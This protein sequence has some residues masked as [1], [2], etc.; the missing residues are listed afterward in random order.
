MPTRTRRCSIL[1]LAAIGA[2]AIA[3]GQDEPHSGYRLRPE[4]GHGQQLHVEAAAEPTPARISA[5]LSDDEPTVDEPAAGNESQDTGSR[6]PEAV[7]TVLEAE[8]ETAPSH[9]LAHSPS[10]H[11]RP[12]RPTPTRLAEHSTYPSSPN[13][14]K[15]PLKLAPRS[16]SGGRQLARPSSAAG[17]GSLGTVGGALAVVLGLFVVVV[18][19]TRRVAPAGNAPLPKEAVELLGRT[20]VSGQHAIQLVRI[21]SRLLLVAL[22]PQGATTLTEI[23][24][25]HEVE[26]LTAICTRQRPGSSS[27]SFAQ[28]VA[29]LE[30]ES[31]GRSFV[32]QRRPA[33]SS[34][35]SR[36]RSARAA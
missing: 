35:S 34:A 14:D 22:S 7:E 24:D 20:T 23:T 2:S 17:L 21:G 36:P 16:E 11:P 8:A 13:A 6:N 1:L 5:S 15:P 4:R 10:A 28:T 25:P 31:A 26:R 12:A 9:P 27:A 30:R 18:W 19:V 29:Q 3:L 33:S 32:D